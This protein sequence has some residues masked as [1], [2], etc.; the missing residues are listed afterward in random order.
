MRDGGRNGAMVNQ[1]SLALVKRFACSMEAP[2]AALGEGA[3]GANV[4][5]VV[6]KRKVAAPA[7][8]VGG[9][10]QHAAMMS[11]V[12]GRNFGGV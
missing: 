8:T 1:D 11:G 5:I 9:V 2:R 6:E 12:L 10:S 4:L 3:A 7:S